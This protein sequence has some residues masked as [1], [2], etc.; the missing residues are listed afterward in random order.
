MHG[1]NCKCNDQASRM[2]SRLETWTYSYVCSSGC[3]RDGG[4]VRL[5]QMA[6][7]HTALRRKR[8]FPR[9]PRRGEKIAGRFWQLSEPLGGVGFLAA[10]KSRHSLLVERVL[11]KGNQGDVVRSPN[12][13]KRQSWILVIKCKKLILSSRTRDELF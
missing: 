9:R 4:Y 13:R 7:S 6:M 1:C 10:P 11:S 12:G 8:A 5:R 2:T 3:I